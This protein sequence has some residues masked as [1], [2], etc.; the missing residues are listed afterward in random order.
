MGP[1]R[2]QLK[3]V[4]KGKGD[5]QLRIN[6][7]ELRLRPERGETPLAV[8]LRL[9]DLLADTHIVLIGVPSTRDG[10]AML[11]VLPRR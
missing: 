6:D 10:D 2:L 7:R 9:R 8:A 5:L 3:G 4:A 1:N 11:T